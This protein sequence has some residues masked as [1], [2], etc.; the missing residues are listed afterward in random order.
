MVDHFNNLRFKIGNLLD[1]RQ[2]EERHYPVILLK[3][4]KL[5][6]E[7]KGLFA[8][9]WSN[10]IKHEYIRKG[11]PK[12]TGWYIYCINSRSVDI[13][14]FVVVNCFYKYIKWFYAIFWYSMNV[15]YSGHMPQGPVW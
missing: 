8:W 6:N 9:N 3:Y 12:I 14:R 7:I 5:S 4:F 1:K 13:F 11:I 15:S 2:L 10:V